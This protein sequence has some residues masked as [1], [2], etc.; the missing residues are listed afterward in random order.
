MAITSCPSE[1]FEQVEFFNWIR[2]DFAREHPE[3]LL[4]YAIPNEQK[5]PKNETK[6]G[7]I[8]R[9]KKLRAQGLKKGVP[10][11]C[12]PVPRYPY[13]GLYCEMKRQKGGHVSKDQRYFIEQLGLQG[14]AIRVCKGFREARAFLEL[15]FKHLTWSEILQR[16]RPEIQLD[17]EMLRI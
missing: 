15:Y 5:F 7:R 9:I 12:L 2:L 14:Y 16:H 17:I 8:K 1:H 11:I 6:T 10:D 3:A 13:H 4:A